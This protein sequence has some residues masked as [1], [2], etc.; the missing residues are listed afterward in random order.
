[1]KSELSFFQELTWE[2]WRKSAKIPKQLLN[3]AKVEIYQKMMKFI[4]LFS[5][6]IIIHRVYFINHHQ[7]NIFNTFTYY[8][9][10]FI[11]LIIYLLLTKIFPKQR[12][13]KEE[14]QIEIL[15]SRLDFN[16][17]S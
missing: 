15:L 10:L 9:V 1:M 8:L 7:L 14:E 11:S 12:K 16:D 4:C 3:Y 5:I 13:T 17:H 2:G 6:L